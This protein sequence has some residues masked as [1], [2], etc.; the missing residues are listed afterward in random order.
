M[1]EATARIFVFPGQGSQRPG[2]GAALADAFPAAREALQEVD[3]A[4]GEHLSRLMRDGPEDELTLTRNAQPALMAASIAVVRALQA[5]GGRAL[6]DMCAMVAGHSLGEYS[7]LVA[8][9]ALPL[10]AAARLLRLRGDAMQAAVPVGQGAMAAILGLE[11]ERVEEIA[12]EAAGDDV[13]AVANDNAPG[14]AV[15]SGDAAAVERALAAAGAAGARRAV[16]LQVSA[17]F[18]CPLMQP[19]ALRMAEALE[20]TALAPP[21]VPAIANVTA[22]AEHAP[23]TLRRLLVDQ[24]TGRVRWRESMEGLAR[25][26]IGQMVELGTGK[27]L[28][29]LARRCDRELEAYSVEDPQQVEAFL[30][31]L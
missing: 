13:C 18:H 17:P 14:Q 22:T 16:T 21:A 15:V 9:G 11:I 5:E 12:D 3:E 31:G 30:A 29:G 4:L 24:V 2:M 26:G 8:A 19:A 23:E 27:V 10:D 25:A 7:A 1:P 28:A 20:R 6:G